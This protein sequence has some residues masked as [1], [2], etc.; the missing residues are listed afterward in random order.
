M[1]F[2]FSYN[3]VSVNLNLVLQ[4]FLANHETLFEHTENPLHNNKRA[5]KFNTP[6]S[7]PHGAVKKVGGGH[8]H[9]AESLDISQPASSAC[10]RTRHPLF[11][12]KKSIPM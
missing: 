7:G 8:K 12:A 6:L 5:S 4:P 10:P 1:E 2:L 9:E 3:L 11:W